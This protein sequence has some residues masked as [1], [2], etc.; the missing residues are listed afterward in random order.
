[1]K[2]QLL[3]QKHELEKLANALPFT[4]EIFRFPAETRKIE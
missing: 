1:M 2:T 3:L 4:K